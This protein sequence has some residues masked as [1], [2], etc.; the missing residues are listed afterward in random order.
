MIAIVEAWRAGLLGRAH[1]ANNCLAGVVV[2]IVAIPL[3]MAFAIASGMRPEQGL[4]TA[5]VAGI[6]VS[7]FGGSRL[8]IAGPTG[9][10]IVI[11]SGIVAEHGVMGLQI[12]TVLAGMMLVLLGLLKFG[13]LIKLIPETVI[14]GFTSG[15]AVLIALSQVPAFLGLP[16][17]TAE[18]PHAK[19]LQLLQAIPHAHVPTAL[20]AVSSLAVLL[21]A[22]RLPGLRAIPA[23]MLALLGGTLVQAIWPIA[24]VATIGS[25]FGGIPQGLPIFQPVPITAATVVAL[26]EPAFTIAMLGAIESLL[27]AVVADGMAGTHHDANQELIGQGLANLVAPFFGGFAATGA[28][29]RTATNVRYG[30]TSPLAGMVH[31]GVLVGV[32]VVLAPYAGHVPLCTLAAILLVVAYTMS[33]MKHMGHM[34]RFAPNSDRAIL[35]LTLGLTVLTDLVVAVN[36]GMILAMLHFLGKMTDSAEVRHIDGQQLQKKLLVQEVKDVPQDLVI[37]SIEGPFFFGAVEKFEHTL[38]ATHT[39]P[40]MVLIRLG[41]VPFMDIT[42]L[43]ALEEVVDNLNARGI[44]VLLSEA[45]PRVYENLERIGILD[46]IGREHYSHTLAS[47]I[48][49]ARA[50]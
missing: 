36:I 3:A 48:Q 43:E 14:V 32:L 8:Q 13:R 50:I 6:I 23:P 28:I 40:R 30:G 42:G 29:A 35:L 41:H 45:N 20:F 10:F 44:V 17:L 33:D 12:A 39:T 34:L 26:I 37:Y 4:Y 24:G 16:K 11:L 27:S 9:A 18:L 2:G 15:I 46:A 22:P 1:W 7:L 21:L 38:A 49:I 47:A 19:L 5:V 31:A 25:V